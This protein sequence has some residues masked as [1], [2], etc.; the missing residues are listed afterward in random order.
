MSRLVRLDNKK[1]LATKENIAD[2]LAFIRDMQDKESRTVT[3]V[4]TR[5]NPNSGIPDELTISAFMKNFMTG[6]ENYVRMNLQKDGS[7]A[8]YNVLIDEDL[9]DSCI[10]FINGFTAW[11]LYKHAEQSGVAYHTDS[12]QT[13]NGYETV[14]Y[15]YQQ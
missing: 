10:D 1:I 13:E 4:Y 11:K 12:V 7:N 14:I 6:K 9:H 8:Y 3:P 2:L 5:S 15:F